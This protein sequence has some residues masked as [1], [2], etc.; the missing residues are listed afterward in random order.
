[1]GLD[2]M[3]LVETEGHMAVAEVYWVMGLDRRTLGQTF[4]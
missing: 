4:R 2:G 3:A 1:M